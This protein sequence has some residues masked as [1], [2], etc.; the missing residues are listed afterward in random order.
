[1]SDDGGGR[2][3]PQPERDVV[4]KILLTGAAGF[5]GTH[6]RDIATAARHQIQPL[7]ANLTDV[8]ALTEEV[9]DCGA[10]V[11]LHLGG[12][13]FVGH[14]DP[15]MFYAVNT[16]GT[17]NLLEALARL[18]PKPTRVVLASSA[19]VYGNCAT[20]P[21]TEDQPAAPVNHY[22]MSKHAM[23]QMA[24]SFFDRL[25]LVIARPF[26]YTGPGQS[27]SFVIPKL[28][29]HFVEKRPFVELGNLNVAR[30]FNDVQM[31]CEAYIALL[32]GGAPGETYNICT[33]K[34]HTL[35][36]VIAEL[37]ALTNHELHVRVNSSYVRINEVISLC[38]SPEKLFSACQG[39][40][41]IL[42][43]PS[44]HDTLHAMVKTCIH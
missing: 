34:P 2:S 13:S 29:R 10:D 5:T 3:P 35:N 17:C 31:V 42:A 11:V 43:Q 4:L 20:S 38:G 12:I 6:F 15:T 14:A 22:A 19:N 24:R 18:S 8:E 32:E 23:E 27:E 26:N 40:G 33:G 39:Q 7:V 36:H 30:E 1:M 21:I 28:V 25:P 37:A 41:I 9:R 44:L 16:V